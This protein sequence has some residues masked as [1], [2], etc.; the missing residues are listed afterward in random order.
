MKTGTQ[1]SGAASSPL[2]LADSTLR[3]ECSQRVGRSTISVSCACTNS[4]WRAPPPAGGRGSR[5]RRSLHTM[6]FL[7]RSWPTVSHLLND[8]TEFG[9][10]S[11]LLRSK[12]L[13][14]RW[15]TSAIVFG[16]AN[17]SGWLHSGRNGRRLK[18]LWWRANATSKGTRPGNV[19]SSHAPPSQ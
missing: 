14:L 8:R 18:T 17:L 19:H 15:A 6:S 2:L 3:P 16:D 12:W 11:K 1:P 4:P 5:A 10:R 13:Q 7:T 9:T